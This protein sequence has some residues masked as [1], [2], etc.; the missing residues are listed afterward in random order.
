MNDNFS[1]SIINATPHPVWRAGFREGVKMS[2]NRGTKVPRRCKRN[3]V[4]KLSRL[5]I[6]MN[7]GMDVVN[8]EYAIL[9][10]REGCYKVLGTDWDPAHQETLQY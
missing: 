10:A 9:G 1:E 3:M 2:L 6:W 7:V 8:G 5:L 4:A